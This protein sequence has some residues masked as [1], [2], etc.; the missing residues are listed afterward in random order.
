VTLSA[1]EQMRRALARAS[2]P[3]PRTDA[4]RSRAF[5]ARKRATL[6]AMMA[7]V[8]Q[9]ASMLIRAELAAI[10][11][12]RCIALELERRER[13]AAELARKAA[14]EAAARAEEARM[15]A[16]IDDGSLHPSGRPWAPNEQI[17]RPGTP[18]SP[19]AMVEAGP[20][21]ALPLRR[22]ARLRRRRYGAVHEFDFGALDSFDTLAEAIYSRPS[23][24]GFSHGYKGTEKKRR[25]AILRANHAA[26]RD[27]A[28][29]P[30]LAPRHGDPA[31]RV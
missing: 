22:Y 25:V 2:R 4:E 21:C 12:R 3:A 28:G 7:E 20:C 31:R 30:H 11:E 19:R 10:T 1:A 18:T 16:G 9:V 23:R 26:A 5:R 27:M 24:L 14:A 13:E 8:T 15:Q 29:R 6:T 17:R